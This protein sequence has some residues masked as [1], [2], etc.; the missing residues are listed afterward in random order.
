M[1]KKSAKKTNGAALRP[2]KAE[3]VISVAKQ[4]GVKLKAGNL[5]IVGIG[6]SAGGL[7]ALEGLLP[8]IPFDIGMAFVIIQHLS[9]SFKSVMDSLLQRHTKMQVLHIE[10]GLKIRPNCIYLG[11]PDSLVTLNKGVFH[12]SEVISGVRLVLPVD[13]FFRSLA[14][15]QQK[16]AISIILSGTGSDGTEGTR[17]VRAK[18]GM[19]MAQDTTQ[20]KFSDMPRSAIALDLID[21][22]LPVEKMAPQL[23][24]Y[25][26]NP[27]LDEREKKKEELAEG[28]INESMGKILELIRAAT[29][30][31]Y[32]NYKVTTIRRRIERR[33]TA[34]HID[35]LGKYCQYLKDTP[36][37]AQALDSD[38]L[39][40]VTSFFRDPHAFDA[41][42]EKALPRILENRPVD[43]PVRVWIPGCA[44]GEE[45]YSIAILLTETMTRMRRRYP[46]QIFATD[47]DENAIETARTGRYPEAISADVSPERLHSFF[48]RED[49][50]YRIKKHIR[51]AIVFAVHDLTTDPP[52]SRLDLVSC[53]NVLIYMDLVLQK[54]VFY[55][56]QYALREGCLLF[57]G[58][59][60]S[61]GQYSNFFA[62]VDS[63][64]KLF[65]R[66]SDYAARAA[67]EYPLVSLSPGPAQKQSL[68]EIDIR[69]LGEKVILQEFAPSGVIVNH[70]LDI[71]F[72]FND[73][74]RFLAPPE[75]LPSFN[76]L[77]MARDG[78]RYELSVALHKAIK[79]NKTIV[80][81]G[82]SVDYKSK[83]LS[84]DVT[85]RPFKDVPTRERLL[86]VVFEDKTTPNADLRKKGAKADNVRKSD[87]RVSTLEQELN[88]TREY[89]QTIIEE[90]ETSNEE[91]K[92]TNEELQ[93]ANEEMQS[94]NE[95]LETSKEELQSTNEE[96]VTVNSERQS[97]IEDLAQVNNDLSNLLASTEIATVFLDSN[98]RIKRFTPTVTKIFNLI[99][100][101]VG[102]PVSD[103]TSRISDR[104][105]AKDSLEVLKTL[106]PKE[107]DI[108]AAEEKWYKMRILPYR[109][110]ENLIEGVVIVFVDVTNL[111]KAELCAEAA[112][113]YADNIIEMA[114]QPAALINEQGK[115]ISANKFFFQFFKTTRKQMAGRSLYELED[116]GWDVCALK[117]K[118]MAVAEQGDVIDGF[119]LKSTSPPKKI[120]KKMTQISARRISR[121]KSEPITILLAIDDVKSGERGVCSPK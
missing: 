104:D 105:I 107:A 35:T 13:H 82:L 36:G 56:L 89:L 76:I 84:M 112:S 88:S 43:A 41:L 81:R 114:R 73:T 37:E 14:Q 121:E 27:N 24:Q 30:H 61:I 4:P 54:K 66:K 20:A 16:K 60:E 11:P 18:G 110:I 85:V 75:G 77:K 72:F 115:V 63:K 6:A 39:I 10:E 49:G 58:T 33:M 47:L 74:E 78:L 64:N 12:L 92:S 42:A 106:I 45:A 93:S 83:H 53:R 90:L 7:D 119:R 19:T 26:R 15:D 87:G 8:N 80:E 99:P 71:L 40:G 70:K 5:C 95:E 23:V 28:S 79:R 62:P 2:N 22:V 68:T 65:K 3:K 48:V 55:I 103:I 1:S 38:F 67:I 113:L 31:N 96:L 46:I 9:P 34:N 109:T 44:T 91:L 120:S 94:A 21:Y 108:K 101:D 50:S 100:S 111:K 51:E 32:A 86:L 69:H 117:E 29:G 25:A 118:L 116:S 102:R 97:K 17:E 52:F 59:S 57:L 98:L